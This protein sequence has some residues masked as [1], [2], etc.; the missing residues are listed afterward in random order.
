MLI[1]VIP[2]YTH[3]H[4]SD[5]HCDQTSPLHS[6]ARSCWTAARTMRSLSLGPWSAWAAWGLESTL[7][8]CFGT[9]TLFEK[10]RAKTRNN[11]NKI[12]QA[13]PPSNDDFLDSLSPQRARTDTFSASFQLGMVSTGQ[14]RRRVWSSN[15]TKIDGMILYVHVS[16]LLWMEEILHHLDPFGRWFISCNICNTIIIYNNPILF[17]TGSSHRRL[18]LAAANCK[19]RQSFSTAASTSL[20]Q[21]WRTPAVTFRPSI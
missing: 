13:T 17:T 12:E 8:N 15:C 11:M 20:G 19:A 9:V 1:N 16:V 4:W 21:P 14:A 2:C 10:S 7:G 5:L 3:Q 18:R 6:T